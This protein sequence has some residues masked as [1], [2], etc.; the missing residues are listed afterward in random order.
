MAFR[1]SVFF[2]SLRSDI[3]IVMPPL[4]S[5]ILDKIQQEFNNWK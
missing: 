1:R 3:P 2:L 5:N 4:F